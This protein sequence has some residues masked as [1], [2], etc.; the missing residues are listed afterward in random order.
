MMSNDS[1]VGTAI[2]LAI[3][4]RQQNGE[5]RHVPSVTSGSVRCAAR[6]SP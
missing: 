2:H 5:G 1:R 6:Q 3:G 4:T